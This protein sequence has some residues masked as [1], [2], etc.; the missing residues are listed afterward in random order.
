MYPR[1]P[2]ALLTA[3]VL[4]LGLGPATAFAQAPQRK[5]ATRKPASVPTTSYIDKDGI[6]RLPNGSPDYAH[7]P[8]PFVVKKWTVE[9]AGAAGQSA[10][11]AGYQEY[12]LGA[13][14]YFYNWL[15]WR[16]MAFYRP[17]AQPGGGSLY[18]LD[19]TERMS[20]EFSRSSGLAVFASPGYR[21]A[22]GGA[23]APLGE[24]GVSFKIAGFTVSAGARSLV[25]SWVQTAASNETQIFVNIGLGTRP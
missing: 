21:F 6:P 25:Y 17:A 4:T 10:N 11:A 13:N 1:S 20:Y 12:S 3:L 19:M 23:A 7:Y 22:G 9:L 24:A 8:N 14:A 2:L 16:N 18:G 5:K 15:A